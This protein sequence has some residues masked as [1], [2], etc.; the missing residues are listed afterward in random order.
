V[1]RTSYRAL[2]AVGIG[3]G[4]QGPLP[5]RMKTEEACEEALLVLERKLIKSEKRK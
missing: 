2:R 3:P 4:G 5:V 1:K